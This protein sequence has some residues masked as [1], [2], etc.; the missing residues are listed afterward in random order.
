MAK[1]LKDLAGADIY[2]TADVI[3]AMHA[4]LT[5]EQLILDRYVFLPYARSGIAA[6]LSAPFAWS[7]P[8][9]GAVDL[10]VPVAD[11]SRGAIDAEMRVRVYGPADVTEIDVRQVVR[12]LPRADA[13]TAEID[14][15]VHVEFDRPDL[16]WL[17]TPTGPD[18][19]GRLTPWI[20][21]VV[22]ERRHL[23]WGEARGAGRAARIRR[24]QLQSLEDAWAWAHAQV[25]GGK[26]NDARTE[27]T[28][29]R[30]LSE[31]N[32]AHNVSRLVC[33]RR[34]QP[35][36]DYVACVVPTFLAGAQAGLGLTPV[37]TLAPAWGTPD[38]FAAGDPADMIALPVY[39]S[40]SFATAEAGNFESL[41]RKLRPAVAPPGVGRRRIDTTRPWPDAPLAAG[42]AG[43][44]MVIL[45]P[46]VS[47]QAPE[48][49]PEKSWPDEPAQRWPPALADSLAER[50]NRADVQ[51][52]AANP[53]PSVVGPPLYGGLHARQT[54]LKDPAE[55]PQPAWFRTLNTDP[56]DRVV[57]GLGTR[58]IQAEQED[59]MLAAWN[60]VEG[61][62]AANRALRR[63]QLAMHVSASLYRRHLTSLDDAPLL[64]LTERVHPKL[65]ATPGRSVW[66]ALAVSS[67][68]EAVTTGAF[69]RLARVRG[70]LVR[71]AVRVQAQVIAQAPSLVDALTVR[72][73]RLTANWVLNYASP[74]GIRGI[75][76]V[77]AARLTPQIALAISGQ[78]EPDLL[79]DRWRAGL[80]RPVAQD[81]MTAERLGHG[82]PAQSLDL[83]EPFVAA[84][85][86]RLAASA[87][88]ERD[89][90]A[91][92]EVAVNGAAHAVLIQA[93]VEMARNANL[94]RL[95][96]AAGDAHRLRLEPA[97]HSADGLRVSVDP[98]ALQGYAARALA[99][100]RRHD[101]VV[102]M[103]EFQATAERLQRLASASRQPLRET[104]ARALTVLGSQAA[105]VDAFAD[106]PR[107]RISAPALEIALRLDPHVTVPR[108]IS[109]RLTT[110][111]GR[112]PDWLR[113][114]WFDDHRIEPVMAHP[115]FAVPMYEPLYR[116][117]P[118]WMIP[119][120]GL[121]PKPDMATLLETNN[122]F[123]EAYLVGLNHEMSRELLWREFPTDQ[124]G[125]YFASFWT[126]QRELVADLHEPAWAG[127]ELGDH[128]DKALNG[129]LV[130]L[131]RGD[132]I[133]RYPGVV[134]H[135]V[136]EAGQDAGVP[137]FDATSPVRTL[138]H[139]H[140][141]PNL[142]LVGFDLTQARVRTPGE[143]WWFT[144]SENPTEPRFGLDPAR[145]G[146]GGRD[147]LVWEDFGV[148]P[149]GFL[150]PRHG[151][152]ILFDGSRWGASSAQMAYLLF[153][154]PGRAA[155]NAL[156][157]LGGAI[158]HA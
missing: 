87:P 22:A 50:L 85:A 53:G 55:G 157:M 112:K 124:R 8:T 29:E 149:G 2:R 43:S 148:A 26:A 31:A 86:Q 127:G 35:R 80:A 108:R 119:G 39:F 77:A 66:A 83:A 150:D 110:G 10:R 122:R 81:L 131:V 44:E 24:D 138:F 63:A 13:D 4:P 104:L 75:S 69:R 140:L 70:P 106:P 48:S 109:A 28:L 103:E 62:A 49:E 102:P 99:A 14:D 89:M 19:Q 91:S 98:D 34:L 33:P 115:T 72:T 132:L 5:P 25:T 17:L 78:A 37:S 152:G 100:V 129:Q 52:H 130:L 95:D 139:I 41:A 126:G 135:A 18:A 84:L 42:E 58:V 45:G 118:D 120:A 117:D 73:D 16:P 65:L 54:R 121:I 71:T 32:A 40:W 155:F 137:L 125:T 147:D 56:R 93:V 1:T 154:L 9:R 92:G 145:A 134:A 47:P 64:A 82:D 90:E 101:V 116:Y 141:A 6:A 21:L 46:V 11:E 153:Q 7:L 23:A 61:L 113:Q 96:V 114:G 158:P 15:L 136:R 156:R 143:T 74:D 88:S 27:P 30:R 142:L 79:V 151:A 146:G 123:V 38:N 76:D 128:V 3:S 12:T 144:L 36:T 97:G 57:G 67:L 60:Q 94:R 51:A 105:A 20:T 133:R 59:L 111:T 68:P 107:P